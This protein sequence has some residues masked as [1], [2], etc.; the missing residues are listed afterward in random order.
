MAG[1]SS[2]D[3]QLSVELAVERPDKTCANSFSDQAIECWTRTVE[4]M[5]L[6]LN[7]D[8]STPLPSK[9]CNDLVV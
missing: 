6:K 4:L 9:P 1:T 7:A 3:S 8:H 2:N 5:H